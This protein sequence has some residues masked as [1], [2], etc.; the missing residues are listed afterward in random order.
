MPENKIDRKAGIKTR[1]RL[2]SPSRPPSCAP[3]RE[4][5]PSALQGAFR[6]DDDLRPDRESSRHLLPGRDRA[7][8]GVA[9]SSRE[10]TDSRR[11]LLVVDSAREKISS[12]VRPT[13]PGAAH[14]RLVPDRKTEEDGPFADRHRSCAVFLPLFFYKS[15]A[16]ATGDGGETGERT[17][18][19]A[20]TGP[21]GAFS[22]PNDLVTAAPD[23]FGIQSCCRS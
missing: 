5:F 11:K 8:P 14:I 13:L 22:R 10:S 4:A 23:P 20:G 15:P 7:S 18:P 2:S 21:P 9:R 6:L 1:G 12:P 16:G 3:C 17:R 19:L